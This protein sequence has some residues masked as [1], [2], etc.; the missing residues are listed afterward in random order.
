[1]TQTTITRLQ[2][3]RAVLTKEI[4]EIDAKIKV[5]LKAVADAQR[6]KARTEAEAQRKKATAAALALL[7][8]SGLLAD[9]E[10]LR[11]LLEKGG[12]HA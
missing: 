11:A 10:R 5:A 6:K 8:K 4:E 2:A 12:G 3:R 1:M 7:E 9:P